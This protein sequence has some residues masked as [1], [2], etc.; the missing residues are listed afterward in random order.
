[1]R[2]WVHGIPAPDV[3]RHVQAFAVQR[4][5]GP[6]GA[7]VAAHLRLFGKALQGAAR[8]SAKHRKAL[9]ST[10]PNSNPEGNLERHER[11]FVCLVP[12]CPTPSLVVLTRQH[13]Q[14]CH[15][16]LESPSKLA[17]GNAGIGAF[18]IDSYLI[19]RLIPSDIA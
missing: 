14:C 16:N 4:L 9:Q 15:H 12:C 7:H 17:E 3:R 11:V 8:S 19:Y 2:L 18:L 10:T 13:Q 1:M 6:S 5:I